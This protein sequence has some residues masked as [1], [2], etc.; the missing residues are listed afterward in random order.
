MAFKETAL[1]ILTTYFVIQIVSLIY[2]YLIYR[3]SEDYSKKERLLVVVA[4]QDDEIIVSGGLMHKTI[5]KGGEIM[6]VYVADGI[7]RTDEL[8]KEQVEKLIKNRELESLSS[9]KNFKIKKENILFLRNENEESL[10]KPEN[11]IKLINTLTKIINKYK[12]GRITTCAYEGGHSDHDATNYAVARA[13]EKAGISLNNV[14]ESP[15]YNNYYI[16]ESI[17]KR[18]NFFMIIK[19]NVAPRFIKGNRKSMYLRMDRDEMKLKR[20]AFERFKSQEPKSLMKR[21]LFPDSARIIENYKYEIGPFNPDKVF[22]SKLCKLIKGPKR[23]KPFFCGMTYED[24]LNLY[25]YLEKHFN[26]TGGN[27]QKNN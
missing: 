22:R 6:V 24:Y 8:K 23:C 14:L 19:F 1:L 10:K 17:L 4:H 15:E 9:L 12:P 11:V 2:N 3:N 26:K 21:F 18:L 7:T 25:G 20:V 16:R 27:K 5:M 13:S